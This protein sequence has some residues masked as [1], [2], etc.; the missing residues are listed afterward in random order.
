MDSAIYRQMMSS[1][2]EEALMQ[3]H[4]Q[5]RST[6]ANESV[7]ENQKKEIAVQKLKK[8][9]K[10]LDPLDCSGNHRETSSIRQSNTCMW[11]P[12]TEAYRSWREGKGSFLWLQGK[13][14][15]GKSVL[16][17][18]VINDLNNTIND[19]GESLVYFYCDFRMKRSTSAVE[20]MRSILAQ[21]MAR[22]S[23]ATL[24][25]GDLLDDLLKESDS[26]PERFYSIKGLSHYLSKVARLCPRTPVVVIDALDEC[27]EIESLLDGLIMS[28][29]DL[30]IFATSRPLQNITSILS[31]FPCISMGK[32]ANELSADIKLHVTRELGS[33]RRL[34]T[35]NEKLKEEIRSKLC[36][37]ADGM[38]RW[39]QCQIDTLEKC[40]SVSEIQMVL[41]SLPEGLEETYRRILVAIDRRLS[42]ARLV[43]RALV[44]LVTAL[45][46]MCMRELLEGLTIDPMRRASDFR[47]PLIKGADLLD[48]CRCLVVHHE[49]T[50]IIMLSHMSV[51]EYLVGEFV[52][53]KL[54]WCHIV[55]EDA[56]EQVARLC[57]AYIAF[58]LQQMKKSKDR[59]SILTRERDLT[60]TTSYAS[61][62]LLKYVLSDGLNH[63]AHLGPGNSEIFK[64][65]GTLRAIARE[66][67]WE[68]DRMCKLVPSTRTGVS[69]PTSEHDF[70][71]YILVAFA[72][73]TLFETFVRCTGLT[74]Q[75]G[76]NPL[77]YAV[78]FGKTGHARVLISQG[79]DV[80]HPGLIVNYLETGGLDVGN[81][82]TSLEVAVDGW[83]TEMIDLLLAEGSIVPDKLLARVLGEHPHDYPLPVIRR[84]LQTGEF[85]VWANN[86]WENRRLLEALL[87]HA[88]DCEQV[89]GEDEL[90]F[91]IK[92]LVQVGCAEALLL[93]AVEKGCVS[94]IGTL[95][96][97]GDGDE[98]MFGIKRLV[99]VG[100]AEALLLVAVEKGCV[101][102]IGTLLSMNS[103]VSSASHNHT[104]V[105][106]VAANGDTPLHVALRL[107]DEIQCF[108]ITKLL[109]EA[110]CSPCGLDA[111]DKPPVHVAVVRGFISVVEYLLS[112]DVSLPSRILFAAL[113]VTP[114]K[115]VEM[116]RLLIRRGAPVDVLN[117][118]R[119]TLLHVAM[120]SFDRSVCSEIAKIF[121][122]AG[123]DPS[124]L[125]LYGETPFCIAVRQEY[126]E[127][128][129]YLLLLGTSSDIWPLLQ[130]QTSP[131]SQAAA[132]HSLFGNVDGSRFLPEEEE[133][134]LQAIRQFLDDEDKYLAVA[135]KLIA[136]P[137]DHT[138][139]SIRLF[140]DVVRRR[141][142][143]VAEYL[144]SVHIPLPC[145]ILFTALRFQVSMVPWL[146]HKGADL[147]ARGQD[148]DTLLHCAIRTLEEVQ[149][150][151]TVQALVGAGCHSSASNHTGQVPIDIAV[152]RG[153]FSVV[154]YLLSKGT[155]LPRGTLLTALRHQKSMVPFLIHNGADL[156]ADEEI[157]NTILHI[158]MSTTD[159]AQCL[160]T[161]QVLVSAGCR[162][163]IPNSTGQLPIEIAVSRGF[164]SVVEYLVLQRIPLPRGILFTALQHQP[165]MVP[166]LLRK[167]AAVHVRKDGDTPLHAAMSISEESQ[168]HATVQV[169][170][171]AGCPT[172]ATNAAGLRP[173]HIAVSQGF[174]PVVKYLLSLAP[175]DSLPP[176]LL[177]SVSPCNNSS[178][179]IR[180]LVDHG[181]N[182]AY[183]DPAGNGLLHHVMQFEDEEE[184][185]KA[186][187]VLVHAGCHHVAPNASQETPVHIAAK[188]GFAS[189]VEYLTSVGVAEAMRYSKRLEVEAHFAGE[190]SG[191]RHKQLTSTAS[192][193]AVAAETPTSANKRGKAWRVKGVTRTYGDDDQDLNNAEA[194]NDASM[195]VDSFVTS[196]G[197]GGPRRSAANKATT[198][199]REEISQNARPHGLSEPPDPYHAAP[200]TCTKPKTNTRARRRRND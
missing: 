34:R 25:S 56:H 133:R 195:I 154:E 83:N 105:N 29:G 148:E 80:N 152:S 171:Q 144:L 38:F 196:T 52:H 172:S 31:P 138:H 158:V 116:V 92:R 93:V 186:T 114:L 65:I 103:D 130:P 39:V 115:R 157:G 99:Q 51:K 33:R 137:G 161:T 23:I 113:R 129:N 160:T 60:P 16:A 159:E 153:F 98:L 178:S 35:F 131:L 193:H 174:I 70:T 125:N 188:K 109:V 73:D 42:D 9:L 166:F 91:G 150:H 86:P 200:K 4:A 66:F 194:D 108:I 135:K 6:A 124:V 175:P 184:C 190:T 11:L 20:V 43:Q 128:G 155:P 151:M 182:V 173:I 102:V 41:E 2:T 89:G 79:A 112:R 15:A 149:C 67:T 106:A 94:V 139:L 197:R 96:S 28:T 14:G 76:T 191:T 199:L 37:K 30:R 97:M 136:A 58:C 7:I 123:C 50:D 127:I 183:I 49:E 48:I 101:S 156:R 68:W 82:A 71:F 78:H 1:R 77:V 134:L 64:D 5:S 164:V 59:S 163:F 187:R 140:D 12:A 54:S 169:L 185:L 147:H 117:P 57:M 85:P 110:G 143:R 53:A 19:S 63:L 179:M 84:L 141:F 95:L 132:L 177:S 62:P 120:R 17:S 142:L 104:I 74:P 55:L 168:R 126:R 26:Y 36:A 27:K 69:W 22:L 146:I 90:M 167:G 192:T 46:P 13:A 100:C 45:R 18:F 81:M 24:D 72:S 40:S 61:L 8:L 180:L 10:L 121:L 189:V 162:A 21:L 119:D 47:F 107:S 75:E 87:D 165:S 32:M 3:R 118:H 122:D 111:D 198:R 44:W 88:E 181:G 145:W 176:D 170:V